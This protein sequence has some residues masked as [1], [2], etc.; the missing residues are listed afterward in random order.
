MNNLE[1]YQALFNRYGDLDWWPGE[2]TLEIMLGAI[3]T[4]N[5]N[6]KNVE[7]AIDN[8]NA[9]NALDMTTL[10][11]MPEEELKLLI[12]P[13]GY[14]NQKSLRIRRL[15]NW[16]NQK[17]G[18]IL[19]NFQFFSTEELRYELLNIKGIG[20][21][22]ADDILLYAFERPIFVVDTYTYR[23]AI[24]HGWLPGSCTYEE[25]AE[26]F[27]TNLDGDLSLFKNYHAMLV[28]IGKN[29]CK[30]RCPLCNECPLKDFLPE[31]GPIEPTG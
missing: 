13:A 27:S 1:I 9:K 16:M 7:K 20:K 5:T 25:L 24:R 19:E 26:F 8:I 23:I 17:T 22:T 14:Y 29:Y 28:E 30:K 4:Q 6:W 3:L 15:L 10:L 21:E 11:N 18:G 2:T 31:S 12:K